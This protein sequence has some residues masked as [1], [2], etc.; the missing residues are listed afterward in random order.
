MKI[1]SIKKPKI[2]A[3]CFLCLVSAA[4]IKVYVDYYNQQQQILE[5]KKKDD[6][7]RWAEN[8][9]ILK[10]LKWKE[11]EKQKEIAEQKK[12]K[13]MANERK[14][15]VPY[16]KRELV[17]ADIFGKVS[18]VQKSDRVLLIKVQDMLGSNEGWLRWHHPKQEYNY[19]YLEAEKLGFKEVIIYEQ[20]TKW[21]V[22]KYT[23]NSEA[24]WYYESQWQG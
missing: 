7:L 20:S 6:L 13:Q 2:I 9:R 21:L 8:E 10:E 5:Q 16:I 12:E 24:N 11:E 14:Q 18:V 3:L 15:F 22:H 17:K 1:S 23:Y 4:S 19:Y